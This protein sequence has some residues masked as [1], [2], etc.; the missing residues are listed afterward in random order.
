[1]LGAGNNYTP[2][3]IGNMKTLSNRLIE[4]RR[5]MLF[6]VQD[7]NLDIRLGCLK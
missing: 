3:D 6:A 7:I 1:M 4:L 2:K 5:R